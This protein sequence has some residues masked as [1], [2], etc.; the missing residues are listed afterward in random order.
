MGEGGE[1]SQVWQAAP[2]KQHMH[3]DLWNAILFSAIT[4]GHWHMAADGGKVI[5]K[6]QLLLLLTE[7]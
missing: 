4:T 1:W 7:S 3:T 6:A 2:L 5:N